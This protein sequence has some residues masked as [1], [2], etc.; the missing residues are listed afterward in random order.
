[1]F[2]FK[3]VSYNLG[4]MKIMIFEI[5][6]TISSKDIVGTVFYTLVCVECLFLFC[7]D[8]LLGTIVQ[9]EL[10]ESETK[11]CGPEEP[12]SPTTRMCGSGGSEGMCGSGEPGSES[13]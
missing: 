9:V 7:V 13:F 6:G 8:F 5:L 3:I 12:T 10:S 1:M 4:L 11:M 2:R